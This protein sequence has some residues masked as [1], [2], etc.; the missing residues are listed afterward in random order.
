MIIHKHVL[1]SVYKSGQMTYK[2]LFMVLATGSVSLL[3]TIKED[4]IGNE[5]KFKILNR[6]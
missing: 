4:N 1:N 6:A 5:M 3:A 2:Y